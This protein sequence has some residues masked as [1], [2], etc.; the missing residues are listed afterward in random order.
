MQGRLVTWATLRLSSAF[1]PLPAASMPAPDGEHPRPWLATARHR[2]DA[3]S[4]LAGRARRSHP[5]T[6][7][8]AVEP[9]EQTEWTVS[10]QSAKRGR[11][12]HQR[13]PASAEKREE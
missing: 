13:W 12:S 7:V 8:E 6:H 3:H 10:D 1:G 2:D 4:A 5:C 9:L 11:V